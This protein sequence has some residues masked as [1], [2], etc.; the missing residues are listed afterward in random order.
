MQSLAQ[1]PHLK[2]KLEDLGI[3]KSLGSAL[4]PQP[5]PTSVSSCGCWSCHVSCKDKDTFKTINQ[6]SVK[7]YLIPGLLSPSP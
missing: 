3:C 6:H 7:R 5:S 4:A 2:L 1:K